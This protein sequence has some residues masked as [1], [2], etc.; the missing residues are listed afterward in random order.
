M[1]TECRSVITRG[2]GRHES[3][4]REKLENSMRKL[5]G[6]EFGNNLDCSDGC[7]VYTFI[8]TYNK[9]Y[10]LNIYSQVFL[11]KVISK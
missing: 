6:H 1:V 9:L 10:T 4:S 8:K 11:N 5:W 7:T 2:C 3:S